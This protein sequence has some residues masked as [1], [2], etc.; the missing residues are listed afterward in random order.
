MFFEGE[1]TLQ[2]YYL[3][4]GLLKLVP[5]DARLVLCRPRLISGIHQLPSELSSLSPCLV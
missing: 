2:I 5:D 4:L 3:L 1:G